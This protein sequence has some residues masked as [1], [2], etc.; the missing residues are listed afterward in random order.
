MAGT[1][2]NLLSVLA[3]SLGKT[4][5]TAGANYMG[6]KQQEK[7]NTLQQIMTLMQVEQAARAKE[8]HDVN[9]EEA[10]NKLAVSSAGLTN[11]VEFASLPYAEQQKRKV[12]D[13]VNAT[14]AGI[15]ELGGGGAPPFAA[16]QEGDLQSGLDFL[17]QLQEG[18]PGLRF[19]VGENFKLGPDPTAATKY[20]YSKKASVGGFKG[21]FNWPMYREHLHKKYPNDPM[22]ADSEYFDTFIKSET[23]TELSQNTVAK[24][25]LAALRSRISTINK[26]IAEKTKAWGNAIPKSDEQDNIWNEIQ[27]LN[28]KLNSAMETYEGGIE[29]AF[30]RPVGDAGASELTPEEYEAQKLEGEDF[31]SGTMVVLPNGFTFTVDEWEREKARDEGGKP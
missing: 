12:Q 13:Q 7:Q 17:G 11:A 28:V 5:T 14:I 27:M 26:Q 8:A 10:R 18:M 29:S 15:M 16:T 30:S 6:A 3:G 19:D 20:A 1:G 23:V 24:E 25:R 31:P 21:D 9:M 22:K 2:E 4:A